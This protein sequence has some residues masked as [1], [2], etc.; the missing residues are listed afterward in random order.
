MKG[1]KSRRKQKDEY[2]WKENEG[3]MKERSTVAEV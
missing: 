1:V 2:K 3:G